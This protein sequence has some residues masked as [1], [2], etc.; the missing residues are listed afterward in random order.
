MIDMV[1]SWRPPADHDAA[2]GE[3][4]R[5]C[6]AAEQRHEL[7]ALQLIELHSI[8]ARAELQHIELARISQEVT[9]TRVRPRQDW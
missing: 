4:P 8:P 5:G 2:R 6:S 9:A 1:S 3:R 7:A